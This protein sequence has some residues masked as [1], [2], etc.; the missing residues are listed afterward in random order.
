VD[1]AIPH[2][3]KFLKLRPGHPEANH[4]L[5]VALLRKGQLDQAI[6]HFQT[7]LQTRPNFAEA[8]FNLGNALL[9]KGQVDQAIA[10]FQKALQSRPDFADASYSLGSALLQKGL[11]DDA[12]ACYQ[13]AI[14][15]QPANAYL[16]NNLAWGF[17]TC[18][19]AA[20]RN[21][22]RAIKLAQE[23]ERLSGRTNFWI[24]GTLA[25]AYAEDGR[26]PEAVATA[27]RALHLA[28]SKT[29]T[30]Q[31]DALRGQLRQYQ[32]GCA[33]RDASQTR[34]AAP[35]PDRPAPAP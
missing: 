14:D 17:A 2:L 11:V 3:Q 25:A 22:A 20:I 1:E 33:V 35:P 28:T 16:L 13:Q 19:N 15:A 18:P 34:L 5:G 4:N 27:Q 9:Q 7:A 26:F 10:S 23:A 8:F 31:L 6:A 32:A 12:L 29:D 24:V 30:A 21:G